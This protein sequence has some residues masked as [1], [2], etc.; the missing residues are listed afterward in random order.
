M[1]PE[2]LGLRQI[3]ARRGPDWLHW[4]LMT[5]TTLKP[6][7]GK[8]LVV[9]GIALLALWVCYLTQ[10]ARPID[11][12]DFCP[13]PVAVALILLGVRFAGVGELILAQ[14]TVSC[15]RDLVLGLAFGIFVELSLWSFLHFALDDP[16]TAERYLQLERLQ[17]PG[18]KIG[19]AIAR[20]SY[21][22]LG[23]RLSIHLANI[24]AFMVLV[25]TWSLGAFAVL[26]TVC[27]LRHPKSK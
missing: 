4:P 13:F 26:R 9:V 7:V 16:E 22:Q 3:I 5:S 12:W 25:A 27:F 8:R 19:L 6:F 2:E 18:V 21:A 1:T 17:E 11:V 24:C 10:L 15:K 14:T 23:N 20:C